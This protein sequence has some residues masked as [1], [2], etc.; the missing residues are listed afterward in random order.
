M[1][2]Q[3]ITNWDVLSSTGEFWEVFNRYYYG[4]TD[5]GSVMQKFHI[6]RKKILTSSRAVPCTIF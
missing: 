1:P 6:E 5:G 2:R 4:V 3:A